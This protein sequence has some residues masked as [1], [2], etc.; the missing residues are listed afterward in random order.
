MFYFSTSLR[1]VFLALVVIACLSDGL[2]AQSTDEPAPT[3]TTQVDELEEAKKAYQ[4]KV[5][6]KQGTERKIDDIFSNLA[7]GNPKRRTKQ[8]E[9]IEELQQRLPQLA[10]DVYEAAVNVAKVTPSGSLDSKILRINLEYCKAC[11]GGN[12]H[13]FPVNPTRALEV[14]EVLKDVGFPA[15]NLLPLEIHA[16]VSIQDFDYAR[17]KVDAVM[18]SGVDGLDPFLE[19]VSQAEEK[20][21]RESGFRAQEKDLPRIRMTTS[22]GDITFVLFEDH[23]PNA[24]RNFVNLIDRDFYDGHQFFEIKRGQLI[25]CGCPE[26]NGKSTGEYRI[27]SE[28]KEE[29]A[30]HHFTGTLSMVTDEGQTACCNQFIITQAPTSQLD[31]NF[32]VIGRIIEGQEILDVIIQA[33]IT[34]GA[35][36]DSSPK[37]NSIDVLYRRP[38]STYR[39]IKMEDN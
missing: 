15:G 26:N 25:R 6:E 18:E 33:A 24:V 7:I 23:A 34:S 20:W 32:P 21:N 3:E 37:I 19:Q 30:R 39:P 14:C 1:R 28:A 17:T 2:T 35:N 9:E 38:D 36:S 29:N 13:L 4:R 16:A 8:L 11:V 27:A 22:H 12:K 10:V 31:G 5:E